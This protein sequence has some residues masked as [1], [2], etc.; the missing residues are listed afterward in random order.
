MIIIIIYIY[1]YIY[2]L[3]ICIIYIFFILSFIYLGYP[4]EVYDNFIYLG[5]HVDAS[6]DTHLKALGIK[7]IVSNK[8][9]IKLY[10]IFID[11]YI[12]LFIYI[13][14]HCLIFIYILA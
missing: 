12:Y 8:I 13:I 10:Y 1:I 14:S 7:Y 11:I 4:N 3:L 9:Y 5:N 6:N 2:I